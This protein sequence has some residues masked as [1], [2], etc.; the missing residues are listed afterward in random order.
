MAK[1]EKKLFKSVDIIS[2]EL[3][4]VD[5]FVLRYWKKYVYIAI[6]VV[7]IVAAVTIFISVFEHNTSSAGRELSNATTLEQLQKAVKNNPTNVLASYCELEMIPKLVENNDLDGAKKVCNTVISSS[8]DVY[9]ATRAKIDLGY[10]AEIKGSN[11]EALKLFT[12]IAS[13]SASPESFKAESL[14]NTGRIYLAIG[15]KDQAVDALKKCSAIS[16]SSS[17]GWQEFANN[18]MNTIN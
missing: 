9:T 12:Q 13:D 1:N 8:H 5:N 2:K 6:G 14:Y 3:D 16:D 18:M 7:I 11:D 15:K 10:I 4:A 17:V